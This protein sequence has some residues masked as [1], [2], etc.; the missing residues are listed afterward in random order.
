MKRIIKAIEEKLAS[1]ECT[2]YLQ[3]HEIE[4]LQNKLAEAERLIDEQARIINDLKGET[5]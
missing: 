1:E 5:R 2:I 3:K 4:E